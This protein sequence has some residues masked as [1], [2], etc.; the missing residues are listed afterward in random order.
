M[1]H[2]ITSTIVKQFHWFSTANNTIQNF[3]E[4]RSIYTFSKLFSFEDDVCF[5]EDVVIE[6]F[7]VL[8]LSHKRF[9]LLRLTYFYGIDL[10]LIS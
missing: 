1:L 10:E 9:D 5:K 2:K 4:S 3:Y 6:S 8:G 7:P